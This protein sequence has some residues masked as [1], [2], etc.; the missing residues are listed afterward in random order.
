MICVT[1]RY[2]FM[3]PEG[4]GPFLELFSSSFLVEYYKI[5]ITDVLH[6]TDE[7]GIE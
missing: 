3:D 1:H 7:R 4:K 2:L 6:I 5:Y